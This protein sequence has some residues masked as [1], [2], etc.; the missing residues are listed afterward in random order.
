M[1]PGTVCALLAVEWLQGES[2]GS[3]SYS[4]SLRHISS[5]CCSRKQKWDMLIISRE[6][7]SFKAHPELR[8]TATGCKSSGVDLKVS[9]CQSH[10][11]FKSKTKHSPKKDHRPIKCH[12]SVHFEILS[13]KRLAHNSAREDGL[14]Q[15]AAHCH[16]SSLKTPL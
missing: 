15:I 10:F 8:P 5:V 2:T 6:S 1:P 4:D 16:S 3:L 14:N 7:V 9:P 13:V 12:F 11:Q